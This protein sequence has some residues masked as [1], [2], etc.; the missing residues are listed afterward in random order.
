MQQALSAFDP[1]GAKWCMTSDQY[2]VARVD[3]AT[4]EVTGQVVRDVRRNAVPRVVRDAA[5]ERVRAAVSKYESSDV[6]YSLVPNEY[7]YVGMLTVDD[8]GALWALRPQADRMRTE[9]D[10]FDDGANYLAS[11]TLAERTNS[12]L[13]VLVRGDLLYAVALDSDDVPSIVRARVIRGAR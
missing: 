3:L 5:I 4:G 12:Y 13:R 6:D 7:P 9:F 8:R 2:R 11:A 1:R 10:V